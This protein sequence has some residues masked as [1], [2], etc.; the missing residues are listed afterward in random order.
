MSL[1]R[2]FEGNLRGRHFVPEGPSKGQRIHFVTPD[3][4]G[5]VHIMCLQPLRLVNGQIDC[6]EVNGLILWRQS[7]VS[8]IQ[9]SLMAKPMDFDR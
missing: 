3:G 2:I 5:L 8:R 1:A 6:E 9:K 7:P 4:N